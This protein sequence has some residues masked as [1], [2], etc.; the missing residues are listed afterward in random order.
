M[1]EYLFVTNPEPCWIH[2]NVTQHIRALIRKVQIVLQDMS[3]DILLSQLPQFPQSI[4][5]Q[6]RSKLLRNR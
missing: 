4:P 3:E 1:A 2:L 6:H 5:A